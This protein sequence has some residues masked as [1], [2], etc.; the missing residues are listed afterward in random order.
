M[1][2]GEEVGEGPPQVPDT[3][4]GPARRLCSCYSLGSV[5]HSTQLSDLPDPI[6][7]PAPA[8]LGLKGSLI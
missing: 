6:P 2:V 5:P 7:G 1:I 3:C 8:S 4:P